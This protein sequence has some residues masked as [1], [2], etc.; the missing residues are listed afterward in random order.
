MMRSFEDLSRLVRRTEGRTYAVLESSS[1]LGGGSRGDQV[2]GRFRGSRTRRCRLLFPTS[3]SS[4]KFSQS[5]CNLE[6]R[7][8]VGSF[9][10]VKAKHLG[11]RVWR[12]TL[13]EWR[14]RRQMFQ[15]EHQN[16]HLED[17][18]S[19]CLNSLIDLF[20][21]VHYGRNRRRW[22]DCCSAAS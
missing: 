11:R 17:L 4:F 13:R 18:Y 12:P 15:F 16:F 1:C 10:A 7:D 20:V 9:L 2:L 22:C 5:N 21:Q 14:E 8:K 19:H 6:K 3:P